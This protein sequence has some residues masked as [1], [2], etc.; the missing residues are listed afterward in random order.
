M[1]KW[2]KGIGVTWSLFYSAL[3]LHQVANFHRYRGNRT[4]WPINWFD[5]RYNIHLMKIGNL[6][7]IEFILYGIPK[8]WSEA[9]DGYYSICLKYWPWGQILDNRFCLITWKLH[10]IYM[11]VL[12]MIK[13]ESPKLSNGDDKVKVNFCLR[14]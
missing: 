4:N 13:V 14:F 10:K 11:F 1:A 7:K 9:L 8:N 5:F 2:P 3:N 6:M 12:V